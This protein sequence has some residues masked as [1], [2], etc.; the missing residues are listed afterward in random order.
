MIDLL[1]DIK[2][3]TV[4]L[5]GKNAIQF[6]YSGLYE[7]KH[8]PVVNPSTSQIIVVKISQISSSNNDAGYHRAYE[9]ILKS[10]TFN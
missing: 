6:G 8:I 5:A 1:A 10:L 2:F 4:K 9:Q 3:N 7:H